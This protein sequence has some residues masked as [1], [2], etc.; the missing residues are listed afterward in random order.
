MPKS[1]KETYH[2]FLSYSHRNA[3]LVGVLAQKLKVA[4][5]KVW[6]D[7]W[8]LIPGQQWRRAMALGLDSAKSC[9]VCIG[10]KTPKG[11]FEEEIGK[12][13]NKQTKDKSF[14]VIPVLLPGSRSLN[15]KDFLELRTWVNFRNGIDDEWALHVLVS[16]IKGIP[17]GPPQTKGYNI[18][19]VNKI[20]E[21]LIHVRK[22]MDER[23]IDKQ[24][25]IESQRKLVDKLIKM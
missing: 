23:L 12:A 20:R 10:E 21:K 18:T 13:L 6:L 9:A 22:L 8:I 5:L 4:G 16:G 24:V 2:V 17:P 3:E 11:W 15:V 25:G 7:K 14:R 1:K 19:P